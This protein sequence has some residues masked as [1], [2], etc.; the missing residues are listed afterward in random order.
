MATDGDNMII[1]YMIIDQ[2]VDLLGQQ[3]TLV[4]HG[5]PWSTMVDHGRLLEY[6]IHS[7]SYDHIYISSSVAIWLKHIVVAR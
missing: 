2:G 3:S 1:L 7:W 4:D 5:R 6:H